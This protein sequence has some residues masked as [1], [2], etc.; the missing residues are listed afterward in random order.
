MWQKIWMKHNGKS[1][2]PL[3]TQDRYPTFSFTVLP[4]LLVICNFRIHCRIISGCPHSM[5]I[6][7]L[8][9]L[10]SNRHPNCIPLSTQ[11]CVLSYQ[12]SSQAKIKIITRSYNLKW[13]EV[14]GISACLDCSYNLYWT[15][16][17]RLKTSERGEIKRAVKGV[18][19]RSPIEAITFLALNV[20][21]INDIEV[22]QSQ[23][24]FLIIWHQN[25]PILAK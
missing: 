25:L 15:P 17:F 12:I 24:Q 10:D 18:N 3:Y 20:S 9:S 14:W 5:R 2:G 13:L 16:W 1:T 21:P 19:V 7:S 23:T 8:V 4:H 22:I 6:P 11:C